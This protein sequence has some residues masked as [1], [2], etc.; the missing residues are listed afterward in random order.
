M[1]RAALGA[2]NKNFPSHTCRE[3]TTTFAEMFDFESGQKI[4]IHWIRDLD[5]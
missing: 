3:H 2:E 5:R 4:L 1:H